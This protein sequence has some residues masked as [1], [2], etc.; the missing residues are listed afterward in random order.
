M[1]LKHFQDVHIHKMYLRQ[2]QR[3]LGG[4]K[5]LGMRPYHTVSMLAE[6]SAVFLKCDGC[7]IFFLIE[8]SSWQ[9][10]AAGKLSWYFD[11]IMNGHISFSNNWWKQ[12]LHYQ[13]KFAV[14]VET[15]INPVYQVIKKWQAHIL[16]IIIERHLRLCIFLVLL[17]SS[18]L[19]HVCHDIN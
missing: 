19:W 7:S 8:L 5:D 17:V 10:L 9:L 14:F 6:T 3:F 2:F 16:S 1:F 18:N 11:G 12:S 15:H 4:L 13:N